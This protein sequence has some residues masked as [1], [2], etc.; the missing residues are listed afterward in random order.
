MTAG[1]TLDAR[2]DLREG[3]TWTRAQR[4]KNDA[5]VVLLRATLA[6]VV[7]LPRAILR[8][9]GQAVGLFAFFALPWLRR[10]ARANFARALPDV[11]PRTA[12]VALRRA[13]L[14]LGAHLGDALASLDPR[15]PLVPLPVSNDALQLLVRARE[16]EAPGQ[17]RRGV[18]FAS[19]H[20]GPW[21]RVAA[22]LVAR[23]VPMTVL[24]R[25]TY[26]PRL[27][28]IYERLRAGRGVSAIY[29]G[30]PG[31][32]MRIARTLRTG[33]VL[34]VPMDL[35]SRVPSVE[36][37]FLGQPTQVPVGPARIALRMG[38]AVVVGTVAPDP[39]ERGGLVITCTE[40]DT[41]DLQ[42]DDAG[43]RELT[44]RLAKELSNRIRALPEQWVWMHDR[45]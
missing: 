8:R 32:P 35:R 27:A 17:A 2:P 29:R 37:A 44:A 41:A 33:G 45:W 42:P 21:E 20:L 19:A 30:H 18:L 11:P 10:G 3:G 39:A 9:L 34:A 1:E 15:R 7:P 43:E 28:S 26:D 14:S 40:I 16:H 22:T 13:Y 5:I 31:A 38:A 4:L 12:Q 25:E 6:V 24:A 23:G 36:V